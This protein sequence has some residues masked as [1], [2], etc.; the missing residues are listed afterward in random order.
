M[1]TAAES[2]NQTHESL[3]SQVRKAV[4]WRS[5]TQIV[6]QSITWSA[7][8]VVIRLLD[9]SDY[10]LFAMTQVLLV[11]L[12]MANGWGLANAVIQ[13]P[14]AD[15]H[16]IR[17][18]FGMLLLLNVGLALLQ[19]AIAPLVAT[20]YRQAIVGDLV[21]VQAV[22]YLTTPFIA[23]PY[24]LL[25]R[26]MD[27]K[28][29]AQVNLISSLAGAATALAGAFA[30]LGVWTL[31]WAP[32]ALFVTRAIGMTIAA[33]A[34]M[35]PSFDF[36]GAGATVRYG[37]LLAV[38]SLFVFLQCQADV[39][40][41]GR[42]FDPHMLGIYTE[43]L[44]VS[45]IVVN[46]FV[47]PLNEIAFSAYA[48]IQADPQALPR[49]FAKFTRVILLLA[50]PLYFGL[51]AT[52]QPVVAVLLGD[53]WLEAAPILFVLALAMPFMTLQVLFAPVTDAVGRPGI[54]TANAATGAVLFPIAFLIGSHWGA[55]GLGYAWLAAWPIQVIISARRTLPVIGMTATAL[56]DAVAP[57]LLAAV[58][59]GLVVSLVDRVL[60]VMPPV[61]HLA[62][63]VGTGGIVYGGWLMLFARA[64]VSEMIDVVRRRG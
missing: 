12:N 30:G 6:G 49:A 5:G 44:F 52:A 41:A 13:K 61:V 19:F 40:I 14:D 4:I 54:G 33:R 39:I 16:A 46:K 37:G 57:A 58:G 23:L 20:Y 10:G 21:R 38:S 29:Q 50:L 34:F 2:P 11:A 51:A 48:R 59:M 43:S 56:V 28:K 64:S 26:A 3:R 62:L 18:V 22:L 15:A 35:W 32:V 31:V 47:P 42:Q 1:D 25:A 36:R 60:P 8:F 63:L 24:A 45:Q 53:K 7:T 27:F 9:P 17:Q 55:I